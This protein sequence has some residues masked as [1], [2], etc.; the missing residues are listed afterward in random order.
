MTKTEL[1]E[2]LRQGWTLDQLFQWTEG[3]DCM[4]YKADDFAPG[5]EVLYIPDLD[6][7]DIPTDVKLNVDNSM[8]K[9]DPGWPNMT[10]EEQI[11]VVLSYCYTGADFVEQCDGDEALA[12][13]LFW[14]CDWQN[15]CS[16]YP[17]ICD[18]ED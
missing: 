17:E 10:A 2:L 11:R 14:Y 4:I 6:L 1:R 8:N 12:Y 15:P 7:N 3:Q 18:E 5:D 9:D 16:A 13:R